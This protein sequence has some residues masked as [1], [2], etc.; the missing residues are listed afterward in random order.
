M[1]PF[2]HWH[3]KGFSSKCL[4]LKI[5]VTGPENILFASVS[6]HHSSPETLQAGALKGFIIIIIMITVIQYFSSANL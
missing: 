4:A 5:D 6:A 2:S 1:S 3:V